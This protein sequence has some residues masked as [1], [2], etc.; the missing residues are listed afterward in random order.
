M[1]YRIQFNAEGIAEI[2]YDS[3]EPFGDL[4]ENCMD[5]TIEQKEKIVLGFTKK[6]EL[7]N[8]IN[9]N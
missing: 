1:F 3:A 5:I 6:E 8:E 2:L 4:W 7:L 9:S